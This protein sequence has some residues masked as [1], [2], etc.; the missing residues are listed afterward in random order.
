MLYLNITISDLR[1]EEYIGSE[2]RERATWLNVSAFCAEQENGGVIHGARNWTDRQWQRSCGVTLRE[3]Q[4]ADRLLTWDGDALIVWRYPV[5]QQENHH[6]SRSGGRLGGLKRAEN[7]RDAKRRSAD[8]EAAH[9]TGTPSS[10]PSTG[11]NA[12]ATTPAYVNGS[13]PPSDGPSAKGKGMEGKGREG[14]EMYTPLPP[15]GDRKRR[16]KAPKPLSSAPDEFPDPI[17][18][19][20]LAVNLLTRRT[21]TTRWDADEVEAFNQTGL[22]TLAEE[23]FEAQL[24]PLKKYYGAAIPSDL[25]FRRRN[26]LRVLR[27]WAGELDKARA[28]VRDNNDG[29]KRL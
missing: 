9:T 17:R 3:V 26:L 21:A 25:D 20:M 19:R 4:K 23:D 14:N 15:P 5:D 18:S 27:H 8:S 6:K 13:T 24:E 11:G 1:A 10:P 16:V 12:P 7:A 22:A 2:P 29:L 28:W